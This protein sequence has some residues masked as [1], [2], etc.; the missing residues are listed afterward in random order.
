MD[1][2]KQLPFT[3]RLLSFRTLNFRYTEPKPEYNRLRKGDYKFRFGFR[4][5]LAQEKIFFRMIADLWIGKTEKQSIALIETESVF[6][7]IG[8]KKLPSDGENIGLPEGLLL[9]LASVHYSTTRGAL[10]EKSAGTIAE[11]I[12]MPLQKPAD[13]MPKKPVK[14]SS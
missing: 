10:I 1:N 4:I 14:N 5:D 7:V 9:T 8:L 12:P 13:L 11:K 6:K 3:F 2:S